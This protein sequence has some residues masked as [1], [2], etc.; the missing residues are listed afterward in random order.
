MHEPRLL[1]GVKVKLVPYGMA[2]KSDINQER[3]Y[4]TS[5]KAK[6][7]HGPRYLAHHAPFPTLRSLVTT[8]LASR[9]KRA[10]R[11]LTTRRS[12]A[13]EPG[14]S[15]DIHTAP[16]RRGKVKT[17]DQLAARAGVVGRARPSSLP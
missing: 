13:G 10:L 5:D 4:T 17:A 6:G 14:T 7:W 9:L 11:A 16:C 8:P 1:V 3:A 15:A 12:R 2:N